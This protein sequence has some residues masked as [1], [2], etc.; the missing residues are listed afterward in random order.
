MVVRTTVDNK[1]NPNQQIDFSNFGA[2]GRQPYIFIEDRTKLCIPNRLLEQYYEK[3]TTR[4]FQWD[5]AHRVLVKTKDVAAIVEQIVEFVKER[6][7][8]GA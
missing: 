7:V 4:L 6:G 2:Y 1:T 3:G 5:R 8:L